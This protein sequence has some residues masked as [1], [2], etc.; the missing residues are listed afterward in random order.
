MHRIL[1]KAPEEYRNNFIKE[2]SE[3][4]HYNNCKDWDNENWDNVYYFKDEAQEEAKDKRDWEDRLFKNRQSK[5][6]TYYIIIYPFPLGC[7]TIV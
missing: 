4:R 3:P 6:E 1:W 7:K 5:Y 2:V